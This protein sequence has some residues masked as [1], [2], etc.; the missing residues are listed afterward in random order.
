M[1]MPRPQS[2]R[3]FPKDV[4]IAIPVYNEY[5]YVADI[6]TAV[7]RYSSNILVVDDGSD[8]GTEKLLEKYT[9]IKVIT[10][11]VNEGY[12][13]SL[14]DAFEFAKAEDLDWVLTMDCDHQHQPY[15]I[16]QFFNEI[17]KNDADIISGSRYL[18]LEDEEPIKPPPERVAINR[19]ITM[20]LN[21]TLRIK[22][23]DSFCG[24]KAYRVKS[25]V[26]LRLTEKGYGLPL[27][28]W[29]QAAAAN[30]RI[31]EIS[32]PLIYHDPKRNFGGLLEVP[33]FRMR[34]Y[35]DI[36]QRELVLN[37][38]KNTATVSYS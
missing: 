12:G 34:Y 38:H 2:N 21:Q 4:L 28:L 19:K 29:I 15:C 31:C 26:N 20:L 7:S 23:T 5:S 6:L 14:I 18:Q 35:M 32:V 10:H 24:F 37:G 25:L 30:L 11:K 3:L 27:Q 17:E 36:I 1:Q 22:L 33:M 13:Q 16:P 8:D 9:S